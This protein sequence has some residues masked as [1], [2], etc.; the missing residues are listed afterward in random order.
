MKRKSLKGALSEQQQ[1][2]DEKTRR[3]SLERRQ[4]EQLRLQNRKNSG[5]QGKGKGKGK[6][7]EN[8]QQNQGKVYNPYHDGESVLFVGEG[9]FSFAS[10]WAT[11]FPEA[12]KLSMATSYDT[13]A[14]AKRKYSDLMEHV[15]KV[16]MF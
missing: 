2:L 16:Y 4:A 6:A 14:D 13:E 12:A 1:S 10:S 5:T 9:N 8:M 7:I 3:E 11:M 15:N